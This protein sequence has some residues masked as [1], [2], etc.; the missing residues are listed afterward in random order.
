MLPGLVGEDRLEAA[1]ARPAHSPAIRTV[2]T[3]TPRSPGQLGDGL[4]LPPVLVAR[5]SRKRMSPTRR[6]P[7]LVQR[8]Q[9]PRRHA[10][11]AAPDGRRASGP[12]RGAAEM[13]RAT[14]SSG[15]S[16]AARVDLRALRSVFPGCSSSVP[17]ARPLQQRAGAPAGQSTPEDPPLAVDAGVAAVFARALAEAATCPVTASMPIRPV[18]P[19]ASNTCAGRV[20]ADAGGCVESRAGADACVVPPDAPG[21]VIRAGAGACVVPVPRPGARDAAGTSARR[22]CCLPGPVSRPAA[23]CA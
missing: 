9:Q 11:A 15:F 19:D 14:S 20:A 16:G 2:P 7:F 13:G 6:S 22:P 5:G 4:Q 12:R 23:A 17:C 1:L 21:W 18:P 8:L 10:D 3:A